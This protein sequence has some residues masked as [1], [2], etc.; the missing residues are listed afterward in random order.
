MAW[1]FPEGIEKEQKI[2]ELDNLSLEDYHGKMHIFWDKLKDGFIFD[3]TFR[4]IFQKHKET[5]I[6]LIKRKIRHINP[7]NN[8]DL[9]PLTKG[10]EEMKDFLKSIV[11]K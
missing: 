5:V 3:W 9:V 6:E 10:K 1:N 8:L 7:I 2:S 4:D 11:K